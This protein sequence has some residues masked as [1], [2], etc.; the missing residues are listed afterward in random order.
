M[1]E[2]DK[3]GKNALPKLEDQSIILSNR[4]LIYD[5]KNKAVRIK[6][7]YKINI[8]ILGTILTVP[9]RNC[10]IISLL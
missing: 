7:I 6:A 9:S 5:L 2:I 8:I 10:L 3:F 1:R 4:L